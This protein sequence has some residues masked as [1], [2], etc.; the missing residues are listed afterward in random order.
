MVG[1]SGVTM[2]TT[3]MAGST[4][5][6]PSG[7]AV[8]RTGSPVARHGEVTWAWAVHRLARGEPSMRAGQGAARA[9]DLRVAADVLLQ[10]PQQ[11]TP[12]EGRRR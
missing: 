3:A 2:E 6:G 4:F 11:W 12:Q 8:R 7:V 10:S 9:P 5:V 1:V